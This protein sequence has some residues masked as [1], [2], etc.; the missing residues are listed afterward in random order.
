MGPTSSVDRPV[1]PA[2]YGRTQRARLLE[3]A[4]EAIDHGLETGARWMPDPAEEDEALTEPRGCFVTLHREGALR[5]CVGSLTARGPLVREVAR[6]AY[7]AAFRDPRFPPLARQEREGLDIHISVLSEPKPMA[8][9]SEADLLE[10]LRPGVDGLILEDGGRL[11]TFLPDV[12]DS[13][14]TPRAFLEQLRR[15]AGLAPDHWSSTLRVQRYTT[16]AFP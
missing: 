2:R 10:Q 14:P 11:G 7:N 13:L 4:A 1:G 3:V 12:W 8:F 16:E 5:G 9:T 6:A 15:K